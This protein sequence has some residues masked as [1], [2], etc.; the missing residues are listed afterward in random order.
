MITDARCA[1]AHVVQFGTR[2][3]ARR[4]HTRRIDWTRLD[5][6]P[7]LQLSVPDQLRR[8]CDGSPVQIVVLHGE[9]GDAAVELCHIEER[10]EVGCVKHRGVGGKAGQRY[11]VVVPCDAFIACIGPAIL[12]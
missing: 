10:K 9:V 12:L 4:L 1:V 6:G 8:C 3:H 2:G 11:S 5:L 7:P